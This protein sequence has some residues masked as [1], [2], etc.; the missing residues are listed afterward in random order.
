M[1]VH[2]CKV[3]KT[4]YTYSELENLD[5]RSVKLRELVAEILYVEIATEGK[6]VGLNLIF[7]MLNHNCD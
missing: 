4:V 6:K 1:N 5:S 3:R 7:L 2:G